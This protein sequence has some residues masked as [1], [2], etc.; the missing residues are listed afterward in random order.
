[1]L[2]STDRVSVMFKE[3]SYQLRV[4]TILFLQQASSTVQVY[5]ARMFSLW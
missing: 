3:G 4:P 1:M 2:L 5:V